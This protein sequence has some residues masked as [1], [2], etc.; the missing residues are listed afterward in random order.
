MD[1]WIKDLI[2]IAIELNFKD[3]EKMSNFFELK[4]LFNNKDDDDVNIFHIE[5][6]L[7]LSDIFLPMQEATIIVL[8]QTMH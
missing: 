5:E 2:L 3:S 8:I 4:N 6:C 7:N 1:G